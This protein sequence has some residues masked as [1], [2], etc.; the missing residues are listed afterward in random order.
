[1]VF[2]AAEG[3]CCKDSA[4]HSVTM[5][6][7]LTSRK[8]AQH[9]RKD[10][11]PFIYEEGSEKDLRRADYMRRYDNEDVSRRRLYKRTKTWRHKA[12]WKASY[13]AFQENQDR[14]SVV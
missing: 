10:M 6:S 9:L 11:F 8:C 14:K 1:M 4:D 7:G 2:I 5:D 13:D 12:Y 3:N